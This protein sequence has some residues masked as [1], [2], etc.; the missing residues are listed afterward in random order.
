MDHEGVCVL[1]RPL[2]ETLFGMM[3]KL[4]SL[5]AIDVSAGGHSKTVIIFP[6]PVRVKEL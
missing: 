2:D 6:G 3:E 4:T 1:R 5:D